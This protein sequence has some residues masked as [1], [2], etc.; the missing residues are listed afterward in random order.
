MFILVFKYKRDLF[1]HTFIDEH[2]Y[3]IQCLYLANITFFLLTNKFL[4][5]SE[6]DVF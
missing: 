5:F 3:E 2:E 4:N 1:K 6:V